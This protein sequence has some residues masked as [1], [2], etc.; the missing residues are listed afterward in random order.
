MISVGLCS[1]ALAGAGLPVGELPQ[2]PFQAIGHLLLRR[3]TVAPSRSQALENHLP[4]VTGRIKACCHVRTTRKPT[5]EFRHWRELLPRINV[6]RDYLRICREFRLRNTNGAGAARASFSAICVNAVCK[7][8][9]AQAGSAS[10]A[11]PAKAN[12]WQRHPP[13]SC[14]LIAQE[15][16]GSRI[17]PVPRNAWKASDASHMSCNLLRCTLSNS[18]PWIVCAA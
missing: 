6:L 8:D 18:S 13:Q 1:P 10:A 17:Q 2:R 3:H 12:A 5:S 4:F 11:A 14:V 16:H 15:R 7:A 9:L